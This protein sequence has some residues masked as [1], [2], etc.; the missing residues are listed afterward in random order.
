MEKQVYITEEERAK[1]KKVAEAFTELYE[2]ADIVVVDVG[3]YG[4]VM[5]KYYMPPHGFEEDA[6]FTDSKVLF[7][8]LWQE[9]LDMK[10]YFMAKGTSLMETG[11]KGI[12]ESLSKEK[13]SELIGRKTYFARMAGIDM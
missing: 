13:Q 10:L 8:G 9:W 6:T 3:R 2:M 1:C 5:L 4:F 12:F 7:E 11:Y